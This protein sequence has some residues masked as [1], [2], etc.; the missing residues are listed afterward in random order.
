MQL[1]E[2][3]VA[4]PAVVAEHAGVFGANHEQGIEGEHQLGA[5]QGTH[6]GGEQVGQLRCG[7]GLLVH[8]APRPLAGEN[9]HGVRGG[10]EATADGQRC[11]RRRLLELGE[12][13]ADLARVAVGGAVHLAGTATADVADHELHGP[14]DGE[15]G[16]VSLAERV[17]AT[18]H[19]DGPRARPV[20]HDDRADRH[21]GGE[22]TVDVE[23]VGAHRLDSGDH[24]GQVL[25]TAAG[26]HGI[27]GDLLHR[28]LHQVRGHHGDD[29]VGCSGGAL[30]DAQHPLLGGWYHGQTIGEAAVEEGFHLVVEVRQFDPAAG[31][32]MPPE[33]GSE[34][35]D[36][37]GVHRQR[38]AAGPER[39]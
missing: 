21:R 19:A 23:L 1:G 35:V 27:D 39:G 22:D 34:A 9:R 20:A 36:E 26:H 15:V 4:V 18:V 7:A 31:E 37:V 11:E 6:A 8:D 5:V 28:H 13:E 16:T 10:F 24:P 14:A 30:Q 17:D 29:L 2:D 38:P 32:D 3:S 25:G 12:A 33:A